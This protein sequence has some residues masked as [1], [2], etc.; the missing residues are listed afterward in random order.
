MGD[1]KLRNKSRGIFTQLIRANVE[2]YNALKLI[3]LRG[4]LD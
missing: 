1:T 4:Q 3:E 2:S